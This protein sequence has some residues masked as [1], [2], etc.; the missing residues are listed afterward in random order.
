MGEDKHPEQ[1]RHF[2]TNICGLREIWAKK[3]PSKSLTRAYKILTLLCIHLE[4]PMDKVF[5]VR[6]SESA[7]SRIS[8]LAR[9]LHISKKKVIEG[10]VEAYSAKVEEGGHGDALK[11]TFGA[12]RRKEAAA[13]TVAK[14][15]RA[16]GRAMAR[17]RA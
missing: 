14:A 1:Q 7:Y 2:S 17:H 4:L 5:S 8:F 11:E 10:A 9:T 6:M 16:F 13:E 15:K 3:Q 12:W